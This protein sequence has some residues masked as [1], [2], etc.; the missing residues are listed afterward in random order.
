MTDTANDL[1]AIFDQHVAH[2]FVAENLAATMATMT[3]DPFVNHVPTTGRAVE[4]PD[5]SLLPVTG[6]AQARKVLD[7]DLPSNTLV[8]AAQ[9]GASA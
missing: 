6:L 5:P 1:G 3:A 4:L 7:K 8:K 9:S 2:E